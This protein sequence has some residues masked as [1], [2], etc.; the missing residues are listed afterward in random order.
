M[1]GLTIA[2]VDKEVVG[3]VGWDMSAF[4]R[5]CLLLF[6]PTQWEALERRQKMT[7][8]AACI[9]GRRV[10]SG[11]VKPTPVCVGEC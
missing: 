4:L 8:E 2:R 3:R 5:P 11:D 9:M 1:R 7:R 6:S 10:S